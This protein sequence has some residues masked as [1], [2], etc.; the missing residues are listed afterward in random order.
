MSYFKA[1][2]SVKCVDPSGQL[3]L[4]RVYRVVL[5]SYLTS[6]REMLELEGLNS[7]YYASRF[8]LC[9]P[10][11]LGPDPS[12]PYPYPDDDAAIERRQR[13]RLL[14]YKRGLRDLLYGTTS[15]DKP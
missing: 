6:S 7:L 10:V 8:E 9:Q 5:V 3:R 14:E 4:G 1:G 11:A 2:N 15:T 12:Q 13:E